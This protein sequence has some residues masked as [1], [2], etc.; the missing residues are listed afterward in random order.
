MARGSYIVA[1]TNRAGEGN[2]DI[3]LPKFSFS[4]ALY[5]AVVPFVLSSMMLS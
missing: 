1:L 2:D 5:K 4:A 3:A